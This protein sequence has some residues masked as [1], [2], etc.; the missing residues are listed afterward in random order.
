[1]DRHLA[2][3]V[4]DVI[5]IAIRVGRFVI[6]RRRNDVVADGEGADGGLD[7]AGRAEQVAGHGLRGTHGEFFRVRAEDGLDRLCFTL[8]I[9]RKRASPVCV[10]AAAVPPATI[11]SASLW[12]MARAA[13]PVAWVAVA[14]AETTARCGPF[15][16]SNIET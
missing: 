5:E 3:F 7:G 10:I 16:P 6:D 15:A 11:T 2:G 4:R 13:S 14:Q 8:V 12:T 1:V 9:D